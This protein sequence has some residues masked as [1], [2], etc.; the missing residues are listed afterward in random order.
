MFMDLERQLLGDERTR[1]RQLRTSTDSERCG[2]SAGGVG[3][4][5][6]NS[7]AGAFAY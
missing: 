7:P 5:E 1:L 4:L 2:R 3:F 6:K